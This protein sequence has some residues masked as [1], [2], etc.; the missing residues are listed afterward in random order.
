MLQN[1]HAAL[2]F[3]C[4]VC[5]YM[6]VCA[7]ACTH[8]HLP[9]QWQ[10]LFAHVC[11][12]ASKAHGQWHHA[13]WVKLQMGV[14]PVRY[15]HA[16]PPHGAAWQ[17][18][19]QEQQQN[20]AGRA[21]M[22]SMQDCMHAVGLHSCDEPVKNLWLQRF[23]LWNVTHPSCS[24]L[25]APDKLLSFLHCV[26][27]HCCQVLNQKP[28]EEVVHRKWLWAYPLLRGSGFEPNCC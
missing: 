23:F 13:I 12:T 25:A 4:F 18:H 19:V 24:V 22:W 11:F 17:W 28:R 7:R 3:V 27:T 15:T 26:R 14:F 16:I 8:V 9:L 5:V 2:I 6:C 20:I 1:R 10:D 21:C